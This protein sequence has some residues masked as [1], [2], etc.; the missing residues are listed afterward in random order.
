MFEGKD[1]VFKI[2]VGTGLWLKLWLR[3]R[4]GMWLGEEPAQGRRYAS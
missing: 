2:T 3:L 4:F 1:V